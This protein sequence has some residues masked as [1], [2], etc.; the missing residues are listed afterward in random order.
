MPW[1]RGRSC[2]WKRLAAHLGLGTSWHAG[3][4]VRSDQA[5]QSGRPSAA[6]RADRPA[7]RQ[8]LATRRPFLLRSAQFCTGVAEGVGFEPTVRLH[9]QR[10]SRPSHSTTLASLRRAP[11]DRSIGRADTSQKGPGRQAPAR[12]FWA[13]SGAA[14]G[15]RAAGDPKRPEKPRKSA[16]K[17]RE[18][19]LTGKAP[20]L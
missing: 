4:E 19:A 17:G 15:D 10:F 14:G 18:K 2:K 9:A 5:A 20:G 16:R 12:A 6:G 7:I 3:D 11:G 13:R 1:R 8:L